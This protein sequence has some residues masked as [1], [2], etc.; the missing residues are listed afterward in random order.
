[1]YRNFA[2]HLQFCHQNDKIKTE[3]IG[4]DFQI[5]NFCDFWKA[6]AHPSVTR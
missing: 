5:W 6:S 3:I 1:M 2:K 4:K